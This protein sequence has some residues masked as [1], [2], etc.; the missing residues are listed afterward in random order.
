[1]TASV[2]Q[3]LIDALL[4]AYAEIYS[5][6]YEGRLNLPYAKSSK[7]IDRFDGADYD[8]DVLRAFNERRQDVVASDREAVAFML[9]YDRYAR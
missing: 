1:M 2:N 9:A 8:R 7:L 4:S 6:L 3:A 5:D